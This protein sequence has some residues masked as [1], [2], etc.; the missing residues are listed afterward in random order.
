MSILDT[1]L[2]LDAL[3]F[4]RA[5]LNVAVAAGENPDETSLYRT[6]ALEL[7]PDG[8]RLVATDRYLLLHA[9]IGAPP[10]DVLPVETIV[11]RDLDRRGRALLAWLYRI[12]HTSDE[13]RTVRL[14]LRDLDDPNTPT[15]GPDLVPRA[16]TIDTGRD[17]CALP[18]LDTAWTVWRDALPDTPI[19]PVTDVEII[20]SLVGRLAKL[21]DTTTVSF[22]FHGDMAVLAA[23][24]PHGRVLC[25]GTFLTGTDTNEAAA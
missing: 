5:W 8:V 4:A 9:S 3:D 6:V 11:A 7:Y 19:G 10:V 24:D 2:T 25:E 20:P 22:E 17:L 13:P 14:G 23:S 21:R 18:I 12:A 1:P 16:L 15:L